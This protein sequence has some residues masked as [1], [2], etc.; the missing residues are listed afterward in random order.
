MAPSRSPARWGGSPRSSA[1][2]VWAGWSIQSATRHLSEDVV[3]GLLPWVGQVGVVG[4]V[5]RDMATYRLRTS[6]AG[7]RRP[8]RGRRCDPARRRPWRRRRL[9]VVGDVA[10]REPDRCRDGPTGEAAVE[11]DAVDG[12]GGAVADHLTPIGDQ[13]T[14]VASGSDLIAD[15]HLPAAPEAV[16]RRRLAGGASCS[17][18]SAW[19]CASNGHVHCRVQ[20]ASDPGCLFGSAR[21]VPRARDASAGPAA[22]HRQPG[23]VAGW[24]A[25]PS[26]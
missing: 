13:L 26:S 8:G 10:G 16:A 14:V 25:Q 2:R 23:R 20:V 12:P 17:S 1:W 3:G 9:D 21:P 22:N 7:R 4:W 24:D 19:A 15:I 6:Q 5:P 18:A 11:M